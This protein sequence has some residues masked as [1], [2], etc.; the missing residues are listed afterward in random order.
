MQRMRVFHLAMDGDTSGYFPQLARHHD[1]N[2]VEM[3]FGTLGPITTELAQTMAAEGIEVVSLG[4][5][6]RAAY[7]LVAARLAFE[8]R[9]RKIDVFHAHLFDPSVV[10]LPAALVSRTPVRLLTRH[11]SDYHTRINRTWHTRLDKLCTRLAHTVIAVS[12]QTRRVMVEEEGATPAK[13]EVVHNG[14]DMAR[15]RGVTEVQVAKLRHELGVQNCQIVLVP[16]RLHPEKGQEYLLRAL[17]E[18]LQNRGSN[19]RV[20]V[21]GAGSYLSAYQALA[22]DL[23]VADAVQ[24][25]GFRNDIAELMSLSDV[26]VLPSTAEAFGLVLL[27]AMALRKAVVATNVGGIP[28]IVEDGKT[29]VL[30]PPASPHALAQAIGELLANEALRAHLG[31]AGEARVQEKFLFETM[32]RRYEDIYRRLVTARSAA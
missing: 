22:R 6:A 10:G 26:V 21:A 14:I 27:E 8:L 1:R 11:Y 3:V 28:E 17:P 13:I 9:K 16:G 30:V 12:D 24:F 4:A 32:I 5:R 25:L 31:R 7:P 15:V 19:I 23:G 2:S 20:L 29:G 18:L